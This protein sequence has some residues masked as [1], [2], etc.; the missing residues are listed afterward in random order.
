MNRNGRGNHHRYRISL[1]I[2]GDDVRSRVDQL[3]RGLHVTTTIRALSTRGVVMA[4]EGVTNELLVLILRHV[5]H[6]MERAHA[7]WA[8]RE[9][10]T[11]R[12]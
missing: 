10:L 3:T 11:G 8:T 6:D 2:E 12:H 5:D 4:F 1:A 9:F 7:V